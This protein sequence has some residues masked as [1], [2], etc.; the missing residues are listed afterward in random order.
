[1]ID[2]V[3]VRRPAAPRRRLLSLTQLSLALSCLL[4]LPA[5]STMFRGRPMGGAD[6][7][8]VEGLQTVL[9]ERA[10]RLDDRDRQAIGDVLLNAEREHRLDPLLLVALIEHES[11]WDADAVSSHSALGLMQVKAPVAMPVAK[12]LGIPWK[13]AGTLFEPVSNVRIGV[14]YFA[15]M[16]ER[17]GDVSLALTAYNIGPNR[18]AQ[19]LAADGDPPAGFARAVLGRY[20]R[21]RRDAPAPIVRT[22][23]L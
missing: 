14:A 6:R 19:I 17:F 8:K 7:A 22:A 10:E 15:E 20:E 21:I 11:R 9:A 4:L 3:A 5:C 13:G 1:M 18:T 2:H 12:E 23:G 16:M